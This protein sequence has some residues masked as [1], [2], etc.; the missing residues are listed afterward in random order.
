MKQ[1]AVDVFTSEQIFVPLSTWKN[2]VFKIVRYRIKGNI[3][4]TQFR[5]LQKMYSSR[6][7]S[8]TYSTN[9]QILQPPGASKLYFSLS[10][11]IG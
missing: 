10:G 8:G 6:L 2:V 3:I 7:I 4:S 5:I 11:I 9:K 1:M